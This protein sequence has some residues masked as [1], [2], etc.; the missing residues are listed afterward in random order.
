MHFKKDNK[1]Y[2]VNFISENYNYSYFSTQKF[3]N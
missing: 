1:G 3:V 2:S